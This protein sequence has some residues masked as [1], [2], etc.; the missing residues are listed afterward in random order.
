MQILSIYKVKISTIIAAIF[1]SSGLLFVSALLIFSWQRNEIITNT[2]EIKNLLIRIFDENENIADAITTKF[3]ITKKNS[4]CSI[5]KVY[6]DNGFYGFNYSSASTT[7][8]VY[9]TLLALQ[10][11]S[12]MTECLVYSANI[13][14][15]TLANS[16][17]TTKNGFR[18]LITDKTKMIYSFQRLEYPR[19]NIKTSKMFQDLHAYIPMIPDYYKRKLTNSIMS[20]GTVAT[21]LYLDII[22]N[23]NTYSVVSFVYDLNDSKTPVAY[24]LYD[25]TTGELNALIKNIIGDK[26]WVTYYVQEVSTKKN[27]CINNCHASQPLLTERI[28]THLSTT[29]R[30]ESEINILKSIYAFPAFKFIAIILFFV[31]LVLQNVIHKWLI[32]SMADSFIDP[33]TGLYTRKISPFIEKKM[34][35]KGYVSMIDCNKFKEINDLFGHSAGDQ[36]LIFIGQA[37]KTELRSQDIAVRY[38]GDEFLVVMLVD[39]VK[40]AQQIM[41]RIQQRIGA[42]TFTFGENTVTPRISFG[43]AQLRDNLSQSI[44]Y[45]DEKMYVMKKAS[46][47][48]PQ[49]PDL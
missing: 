8:P 19:F 31:G 11:V 24:L 3:T 20:K 44:Q 18:Y 12:K 36:V 2:S 23:A 9:G 10:P 13:I 4:L 21:P 47:L 43:I 5:P 25:H 6:K 33:L 29:F 7:T 22:T 30:L 17:L 48:T 15:S 40:K 39:E 49:E 38:G 27:M 32:R 37:I 42:R 35:Y 34:K 28:S 14:Q 46:Q 41:K 26:D 45:A 1:I 16:D